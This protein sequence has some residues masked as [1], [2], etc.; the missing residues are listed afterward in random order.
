MK[1]K[2]NMLKKI[3]NMISIRVC[4]REESLIPSMILC[5][6]NMLEGLQG[7]SLSV[8]KSGLPIF[9]PT[10]AKSAAIY[11]FILKLPYGNTWVLERFDDLF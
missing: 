11:H 6:S 9:D 3:L 5:T 8:V 4:H 2:I 1:M 7:M 10:P